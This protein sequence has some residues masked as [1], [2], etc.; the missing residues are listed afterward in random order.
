MRTKGD[1]S[2]TQM[3][4][5]ACSCSLYSTHLVWWIRFGGIPD[6]C[7]GE[8]LGG[9]PDLSQDLAGVVAAKHGQLVHRPVPAA[10]HRAQFAALHFKYALVSHGL[11]AAVS[12]I[13][14]M[15]L[16]CPRHHNAH[17]CDGIA[18]DNPFKC[19]ETF[20]AAERIK[21]QSLRIS[22]IETHY[23]KLRSVVYATA[24]I[25][26]QGVGGRHA[27]DQLLKDRPQADESWRAMVYE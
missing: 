10:C 6:V 19:R 9:V 1:L 14:A 5:S 17:V 23:P 2:G 11:Q 15:L 16:R 18:R 27:L 12:A 13:Q 20:T 24:C 26:R 7:R 8:G 25:P 4:R 3:L 22:G 21:Q